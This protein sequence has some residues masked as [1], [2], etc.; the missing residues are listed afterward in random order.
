MGQ[1]E[2]RNLLQRED[3][4]QL[5]QRVSAAYHLNPLS[6]KEARKYIEYRLQIAGATENIF[7]PKA[8]QMIAEAS[9][10]VPRV[11]NTI[12]D[13]AL[14]YGYSAGRKKIDIT[15]IRSVLEDRREMGLLGASSLP[16]SDFGVV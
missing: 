3:L 1:P 6:P 14:V 7:S 9:G 12:C 16:Q 5:T 4:R 15:M 11:I 8:K 13:L 10:G 2:L